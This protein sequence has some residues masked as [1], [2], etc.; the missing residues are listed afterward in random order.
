MSPT[1]PDNGGGA[2]PS[3][4]APPV[5]VVDADGHVVEAPAFFAELFERFPDRIGVR[6]DGTPGLLIEGRPYPDVDGPGAGCPADRGLTEAVGVH[7]SSAAGVLADADADG[8]GDMVLYPSFALCVPTIRD[9]V[10]GAAIARCYNRWVASLCAEGGGRLHAA[11]V[12]P[13]EHGEE[14]L[15]VLAEASDLGLA[16]VTVPPALAGRNLDHPD[17][18][19]FYAAVC[20]RD[21]AIGVHGAPGIHLPKI[22]VDR[23]SNYV[24]VHCVSFPFDQMTAVTAM[25]SGG[26]FDRH[27]R[28]RVAFLESGAGWLP[29]FMER[30]H[31]HWASR[32]DWVPDGWRR[33]PGEYVAAGNV[34]VT[35]EPDETMLPAVIDSLGDGCVMFAS[36]YPHWD[37][38]WPHATAEL[39]AHAQGR[40]DDGALAAVAAGNARRFYGLP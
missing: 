31:E 27:P 39:V 33:P 20:D 16:A 34:W 24:Q 9:P 4:L 25:V 22:G 35:C 18:D 14:A 29:W 30:L 8:I 7:P 21:M 37:G 17:L 10:L 28:L 38:A 32:G 15:A 3:P 1:G 12:V 26:V 6:R 19:P 23:F 13:L 40:L 11:A 2:G 5:R 36:D